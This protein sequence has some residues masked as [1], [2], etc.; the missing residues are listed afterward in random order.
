MGESGG[1]AAIRPRR[2]NGQAVFGSRAEQHFVQRIPRRIGRPG[3]D[4][5]DIVTF[6]ILARIIQIRK[7]FTTAGLVTVG[8]TRRR[9]LCWRGSSLACRRNRTAMPMSHFYL[10]GRHRN[11]WLGARPEPIT[12][13]IASRNHLRVEARLR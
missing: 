8:R 3:R 10:F 11:L 2:A 6:M 9:N 5:G 1:F 4:A 7:R 13:V 12:V